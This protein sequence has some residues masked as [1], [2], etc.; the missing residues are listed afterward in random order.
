[1]DEP[2]AALD[3]VNCQAVVELIAEAKA[4]GTTMVG[5]FHDE[6]VRHKVADR[7]FEI[8]SGIGEA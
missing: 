3:A 1:L 6:E 7:V 2:T 4:R 5:V 8:S